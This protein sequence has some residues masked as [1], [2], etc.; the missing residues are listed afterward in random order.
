MS[1]ALPERSLSRFT[2]S[3]I[4]GIF[5]AFFTF[6][7]LL[8]LAP[9]VSGQLRQV[10]QDNNAGQEIVR[11][12]FYTPTEGYVAFTNS[13]G[14]T[15]DTGHTFISK[16]ITTQ[17]VDF[18]GYEV[19]ITFGF[20]V[21]GVKAF[22]KNRLI[23]YGDYGYVPAILYS[24]DGGNHF[25][26]VYHSQFNPFEIHTGI[27][28]VRFSE[29]SG[30][31]FA[32][33]ADR[34]LT[35]SDYGQSWTITH[36]AANAYMS[37]IEMTDNSHVW[38]NSANNKNTPLL[39]T[40]NGKD[41][42]VVNTPAG[43]I[44][45][46]SFISENVGWIV[47]ANE[48]AEH[49]YYTANGGTTWLE[50]AN[51]RA[52]KNGFSKMKFISEKV[53]YGLSESFVVYKTT[54]GGS[55]WERLQRIPAF[56]WQ[57]YTF[58]D[59]QCMGQELLWVGGGHGH[60]EFSN[61]AGGPVIPDASFSIDTTG[62]LMTNVVKLVNAS[63]PGYQY[64]WLLNGVLLSNNYHT[65]YNH[66]PSRLTDT[67][68]LVV[69]NQS[70]SDTLTLYQEYYPPVIVNWF[71]PDSA[72]AGETIKIAGKNFYNVINVALGGRQTAFTVQSADTILAQVGGGST[73]KVEVLTPMGYGYKDG[74][75]YL[76][77]PVINNF[78]PVNALSG[79]TITI[80]G[81]NL[82]NTSSIIF[83]GLPAASFKVISDK[84]VR[85]VL[86]VGSTGEITLKTRGG[87]VKAGG[88]KAM[89][90]VKT[91]APLSGT[92]GTHIEITG[93]CLADVTSIII[94]NTPVKSFIIHSPV[95][96]TAIVP[97][98]A[99]G[100]V[101][102]KTVAGQL[103]VGNFIYYQPP[104]VTGFK[105]LT[106]AVGETITIEGT[107][108]S[109][110]AADNMVYFGTVRAQVITATAVKLTVRVP[111]GA[112]YAPISVTR[113]YLSAWSA[114]KFMLTFPDGGSINNRSFAPAIKYQM[115][116]AIK[117]TLADMDGDGKPDLMTPAQSMMFTT[118]R[119]IST[120]GNIQFADQKTDTTYYSFLHKI[121]T[122]DMDGDGRL[123]LIILGNQ[124][125]GEINVILNT[126]VP[127]QI[128]YGERKIYPGFLT[129][130]TD[131]NG[132]GRPDIVCTIG[133]KI[134]IYKN[135][136]TAGNIL[137]EEPVN[138]GVNGNGTDVNVG[139]SNFDHTLDMNGDGKPDLIQ[140]SSGDQSVRVIENTSTIENIALGETI[141][142]PAITPYDVA[143]GDVDG[144]GKPDV[145]N[146]NVG[147]N[148]Y[149]IYRNTSSGG[150]MTFTKA[151]YKLLEGPST[152][153]LNDLDG[154]G[155]PDLVVNHSV[156]NLTA[157]KT[158]VFKNIS[159]P[160]NISFGRSIT[161]HGKRM[162]Q[163]GITLID[164]DGDG[165][166]DMV[167]SDPFAGEM[168]IYRN[169]VTAG[170]CIASF[171]P[172]IGVEG[173][174][175]AIKGNLF[176]GASSVTVGGK[177]VAAIKSV[178]DT[179]IT[180]LLG[181]TAS[182]E[183]TVTTPQGSD[184]LGGF[185]FGYPP[186]ITSVSPITGAVGSTVTIT[187]KNFGNSSAENSVSF[188]G[189]A[190]EIISAS[191]NTITAKV[192]AGAI[193]KPLSVTTGG[194]I[195][196]STEIF[197]ITFP[198]KKGDF[199]EASFGKKQ[200]L[201]GGAGEGDIADIDGDGKPDLVSGYVYRNTSSPGSISFVQGVKLWGNKQ[202][203]GDFNGDGKPDMIAYVGNRKAY[204]Y[205]NTSSRGNISFE[206]AD[207]FPTPENPEM[208][209]NDYDGDG[210]ADIALAI[211]DNGV[212]VLPNVS[213]GAHIRFGE[214]VSLSR[215]GYLMN[216]ATG[217]FN[218]DGKPDI[219]ANHLLLNKSVPGH[220]VF[221]V[222]PVADHQMAAGFT[223]G[224]LNADG[225]KDFVV[226]SYDNSR[227]S[228]Y[229]NNSTG[230]KPGFLPVQEVAS[231]S[232]MH[233]TSM[234]DIDG[235]GLIDI[236]GM[237]RS[238]GIIPL[239][240]NSTTGGKFAMQPPFRLETGISP[241]AVTIINDLD[242]DHQPDLVTFSWGDQGIAIFRNQIGSA[243][244]VVICEN[245]DTTLQAKASG[246]TYAWQVNT[247]NGFT[248]VPNTAVYSGKST[249]TLSLKKAPGSFNGYIY[250][251]LVDGNAENEIVLTVNANHKPSVYVAALQE[252]ICPGTAFTLTASPLNGGD[253][254]AYVW[255]VDD[256]IMNV[257]G[258]AFSSDTFTVSHQVNVV[259]TSNMACVV[260]VSDTAVAVTVKVSEVVK[261]FISLRA[262]T[263]MICNKGKVIFA[264][265]SSGIPSEYFLEWRLNGQTIFVND[266]YSID[267]LAVGDQVSVIMHT[268]GKRCQPYHS[269]TSNVITMKAA[270]SIKVGGTL[271]SPATAC[272][273]SI[274]P[275]KFNSTS[276]ENG[277]MVKVWMQNSNNRVTQ[278]GSGTWMGDALDFSIPASAGGS[279]S[280]YFYC[281]I[282]P[283]SLSC[284]LSGNS[285]TITVS[286]QQ[287]D[288]P[289]VEN[290]TTFLLVS[291]LPGLSYSWEILLPDGSWVTADARGTSYTPVI[292]GKYR[293]VVTAGKCTAIS[294]P[295]DYHLPVTNVGNM[296]VIFPNPVTTELVLTNLKAEDNWETLDILSISGATGKQTIDV[297][298]KNKVTVNIQSLQ[299]GYYMAVLKSNTRQPYTL[300]FI[301]M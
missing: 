201:S 126:S 59:I 62:A 49:L 214:K 154:D 147:F 121:Y 30:T 172:T 111:A 125:D 240:R 48:A 291:G 112:A 71:A 213:D 39:K 208:V 135:Y 56:T 252:E 170:P 162:Q 9:G 257:T 138:T 69:T 98:N 299:S 40:V 193:Y 237:E 210:K 275:L 60:L 279:G 178:T 224:D 152:V 146:P 37:N 168:F 101:T 190:A 202:V 4:P 209:V 76:P 90:S 139:S 129:G 238:T 143:I 5:S 164:V 226:S 22:D 70:L 174:E 188:G 42:T 95:S 107:N 227:L 217:D 260:P 81:M 185:N 110:V 85:A 278:V 88:F 72:A 271:K 15:T 119:N 288:K 84:Q 253:H 198:G 123:D 290:K 195:G 33:D 296:P 24:A 82:G 58:N 116:G 161:F 13:I 203:V 298:G 297:R 136:S 106:A 194:R 200:I 10:Y 32:V 243:T 145:I 272:V 127:G 64:S 11:M 294:D 259:M 245:T 211:Y 114:D 155:R 142:I 34:V 212:M 83:G 180:V 207:S 35:T 12:C 148:S 184:T 91:A 66:D 113:N 54:D 173:T 17:N 117:A 47:V 221:E 176:T 156:E 167:V 263:E 165:K 189:I 274:L 31:G 29:N 230:G 264:I 280:V 261:S 282:T 14:Y 137:M 104:V 41:F 2:H 26:L 105:P 133:D 158:E 199:D 159:T 36:T 8:L 3:R 192:P 246:S 45:A 169:Q 160:G 87:T 247:G 50:K 250:R 191:G 68:S 80:N 92:V 205:R 223:A 99:S 65:T 206:L 231:G 225:L 157:G 241:A 128:S 27:K 77:P 196:Y 51:L 75:T 301:K 182:G 150:K 74:F 269:D 197:T 255:K 267:K 249:A 235:D 7:L 229:I 248:D 244:N 93:S 276:A 163:E 234:G 55:S 97:L 23:V 63:K 289:L 258:P 285:D 109:T 20:G 89:P 96:V 78:V 21:A 295:V 16:S 251:C 124:R 277:S 218:N 38:I 103:T 266:D 273:G 215:Y 175:M 300:R 120:P 46:T 52:K 204:V 115:E 232:S 287:P 242:G 18:S 284:M 67:I 183:V 6:I 171:T 118:R 286:Y 220:F 166:N 19:N 239:T 108:F 262:S 187:G 281:T 283:P 181:K 268:L 236:A 265:K 140:F 293:V 149:Q 28:D 292:D 256:K 100:P 186:V 151:L 86:G 141:E 1:V 270:G 179:L 44:R 57:G 131:M 102:V 73:G 254:P 132:D 219:M 130:V 233:Y 122:Q 216:I 79:D 53:G 222:V 144:D 25:K 43:R 177:P 134:F 228:I 94:G 153:A 61:N